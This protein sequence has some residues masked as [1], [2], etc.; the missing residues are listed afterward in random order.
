MS[1]FECPTFICD[2]TVNESAIEINM[3]S[4]DEG[5][6]VGNNVTINEAGENREEIG[7]EQEEDEE[8]RDETEV[9]SLECKF[10]RI[11]WSDVNGNEIS[12]AG[13]GEKVFMNVESEG[14]DG[15]D[16]NR[17]SCQSQG[18]VSGEL[19]CVMTGI[20]RCKRIDSSGCSAIQTMPQAPSNLVVE[21]LEDRARLTWQDNSDNEDEF[22]I[23][24][25][26]DGVTWSEITRGPKDTTSYEDIFEQVVSITG[27]VIRDFFGRVRN[28][29]SIFEIFIGD[30][31][32]GGGG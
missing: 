18:F 32:F 24:R 4:G 15:G 8:I 17:E 19:I 5:V 25:S 28:V 10:N 3:T 9:R 20:D 11:Y 14:C 26:S 29:F 6:E 13:N 22:V 27:N 30:E 16:L 21:K 23:E 2:S 31:M 1:V 12:G 7:E